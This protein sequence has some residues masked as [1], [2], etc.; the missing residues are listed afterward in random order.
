M[1]TIG[2]GKRWPPHVKNTAKSLANNGCSA[3]QIVRLLRIRH[4]V[5]VSRQTVY[6]LLK[7]KKIRKYYARFVPFLK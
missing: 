6:K 5:T 1:E 3:S 4:N 2:T 7:E